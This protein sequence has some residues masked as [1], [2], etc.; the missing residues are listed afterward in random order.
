M[1]LHLSL[2]KGLAGQHIHLEHPILILNVAYL[3]T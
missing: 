3:A 1:L 2:Q